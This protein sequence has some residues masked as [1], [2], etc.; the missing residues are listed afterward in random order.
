MLSTEGQGGRQLGQHGRSRPLRWLSSRLG[1][2]V[3]RCAGALHHRWERAE[4]AVWFLCNAHVRLRLR[5]SV[6]RRSSPQLAAAL[7]LPAARAG[8]GRHLCLGRRRMCFTAT[9]LAGS[10][11]GDTSERPERVCYHHRWS[12]ENTARSSAGSNSAAFACAL[13]VVRDRP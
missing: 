4:L 2:R 9:A 10:A 1:G 6:H 11:A 5:R 12:P 3:R 13:G 7:V 8:G